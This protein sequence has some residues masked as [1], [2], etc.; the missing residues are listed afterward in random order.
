MNTLFKD[1]IGENPMVYFLRGLLFILITFTGFCSDL[2]SFGEDRGY[3]KTR[4]QTTFSIPSEYE[5]SKPLPQI[6]ASKSW[7]ILCNTRR[8][9]TQIIGRLSLLPPEQQ[10]QTAKIY[11]AFDHRSIFADPGACLAAITGAL[12]TEGS[13]MVRYA[14]GQDVRSF[15]MRDMVFEDKSL[16]TLHMN[17]AGWDVRVISKVLGQKDCCILEYTLPLEPMSELNILVRALKAKL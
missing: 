9:D 1:L 8:V 2:I 12:I 6:M 11:L 13:I 7:S 15:A 17:C 5:I 3:T 10:T 16:R 14:F 4:L